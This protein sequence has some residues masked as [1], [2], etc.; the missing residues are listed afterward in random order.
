MKKIKVFIPNVLTLGNLLCGC[1]ALI[2]LLG[3]DNLL[4][5]RGGH[6]HLGAIQSSL[7]ICSRY[8]IIVGLIFTA[9]LFDFLDGFVARLLGVQ[10]E[11]GKQLDSLADMV[12]FGVLPSMMLFWLFRA[13]GNLRNDLELE[14]LPSF[15]GVICLF[16]ALGACYR[17]AKFNID[18]EQAENFKGLATP[19][20]TL[21]VI[22]LFHYTYIESPANF[23]GS[24]IGLLFISVLLSVMMNIN[25]SLFSLKIKNFSWKCNWFRY[26]LLIISTGLIL[27]LQLSAFAII[28]P[29][30]ILLSIVVRKKIVGDNS[31]DFEQRSKCQ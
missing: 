25:L 14:F 12:T 2:L 18:T 3:S 1:L 15:L 31:L 20:M 23:F 16:V 28:I 11:I 19:A 17:L 10:S 4:E 7:A 24:Q 29:L 13:K 27:W 26:L 8:T 21:F 22:G 9:M 6:I 30:Y 5:Q